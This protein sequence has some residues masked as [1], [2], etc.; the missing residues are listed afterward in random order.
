MS[1]SVRLRLKREA[2]SFFFL[3]VFLT[4]YAEWVHKSEA[5]CIHKHAAFEDIGT[6][7]ALIVD[8]KKD[9]NNFAVNVLDFTWLKN[10]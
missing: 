9:F 6:T 1:A 5:I 8:C 3:S 10:L 7:F 4:Q 2:N